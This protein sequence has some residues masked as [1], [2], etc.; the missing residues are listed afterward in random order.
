MSE[1][2]KPV[3]GFRKSSF[4]GASNPDCVEVG[5]ETSEVM[6]RDSKDQDGP[7]L[8]FTTES[9][10]RSWPALRP[11]NSTCPD[12]RSAGWGPHSGARPP[13]R[14]AWG[15]AVARRFSRASTAVNASR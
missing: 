10:R 3:A 9:G 6:M 1:F 12:R 8:R 14:P 5:F 15:F 7:V 2:D 11:A 13:P 4:S